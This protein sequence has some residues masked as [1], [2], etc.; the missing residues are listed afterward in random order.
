MC[1]YACGCVCACVCV[2]VDE[3]TSWKKLHLVPVQTWGAG[4]GRKPP[5]NLEYTTPWRHVHIKEKYTHMASFTHAERV[6]MHW[7]MGISRYLPRCLLS[8]NKMT[9]ADSRHIHEAL[10]NYASTEKFSSSHVWLLGQA[11]NVFE[12]VIFQNKKNCFSREKVI[13][14]VIA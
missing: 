14:K 8:A 7:L 5:A 10:K 1:V 2:G 13:L 12:P 4:S 9:F 6:G 11:E 3:G